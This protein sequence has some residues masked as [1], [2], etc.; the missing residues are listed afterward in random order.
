MIQSVFKETQASRGSQFQQ[1]A[2][3]TPGTH[4]PGFTCRGHGFPHLRGHFVHIQVYCQ[5][6][7]PPFHKSLTKY[8]FHDTCDAGAEKGVP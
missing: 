1:C 3:K 2:T 8:L 4:S 5:V 7:H 6:A